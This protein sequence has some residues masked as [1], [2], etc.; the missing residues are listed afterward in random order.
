MRQHAV[1]AIAIDDFGD[2]PSLNDLPVPAEGEA[3]V[4]VPASS[5]NGFDLAVADR[6]ASDGPGSGRGIDRVCG[7]WWAV[8]MRG[9]AAI[10]GREGELS[11]LVGALAGDAR[12]VLVSGDAGSAR[13]G[14]WPRAWSGPGRPGW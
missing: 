12:M 9:S 13:P 8:C 1:K 6:Y 4:R 7:G 2:P 10:V 5:V 14:W 11:R 3:R